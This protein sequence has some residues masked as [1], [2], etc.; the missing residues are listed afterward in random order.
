MKKLITLPFILLFLACAKSDDPSTTVDLESIFGVAQIPSPIG[1]GRF[2]ED[3]N[4]GDQERQQLDILF[5]ENSNPTGVVI[6]F[7]GGGFI[8]GDKAQA[9]D[10]LLL[11]TMQ[12]V[13]EKD[14]AIVSANYSL[15]T[16]TGNRGVISALE[17]GT[18]AISFIKSHLSQMNIPSNKI[19]LAGTSAGAGIAQWN[20]FKNDLNDQVQGVVAIAAQSTY[21]LYEWE[22][23]FI[24]FNLDQL[25]QMSPD[26]QTLFLEFYDGEPTQA[27][28]DAV[29][30]RDFMDATDPS[31]YVYNIAGD[32]VINAQGEIDFDV[33]YHSYLH[34]DYLRR[35]A[36]EVGQAFSGG[37]QELPDAFILRKLK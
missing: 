9:F 7:H 26:L 23:V 31:L 6:F 2:F 30:Y 37:F 28:L 17:D 36:I 15:L 18:E 20:G 35:K 5:P 24:G 4:Y 22:N 13:L 16:T 12:A 29:D 19:I 14:I 1:E 34:G 33:L 25:R 27:D 11:E 10:D 3:I 8:G 21:D 32:E